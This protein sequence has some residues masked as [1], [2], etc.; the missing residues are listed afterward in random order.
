M[1]RA[2]LFHVWQVLQIPQAEVIEKKLRRFVEKRASGDFGATG[3]FDQAAFHQRLQHA[4]D[5]DAANRFDIGACDWL[6]IGDNR[7]RL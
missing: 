6:A 4:V 3:D 7:E 5:V 1:T 2:Q